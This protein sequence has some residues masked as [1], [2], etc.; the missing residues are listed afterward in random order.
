M[1]QVKKMMA[2]FIAA[3]LF[4]NP[5]MMKNSI[6]EARAEEAGAAEETGGETETAEETEVEAETG[7]IKET[8]SE[9]VQQEEAPAGEPLQA[10]ENI[11]N[12]ANEAVKVVA[13]KGVKVKGGEDVSALETPA[14]FT[15]EVEIEAPQNV[16]VGEVQLAY[17]CNDKT[18]VYEKDYNL[19]GI[20]WCPGPEGGNCEIEVNLNEYSA[21][22]AYELTYVDVNAGMGSD[23]IH[24]N[25]N[26]ETQECIE[27]KENAE[28]GRRFPYKGEANFTVAKSQ[29]ED[30]VYP[31]ILSVKRIT[32][33]DI[34]GDTEIQYEVEYRE[35]GSGVKSISLEFTDGDSFWVESFRY[36]GDVLPAGTGK[37]IISSQSRYP[38]NYYLVSASI[39]DNA[40]NQ[41]YYSKQENG[42][43]YVA[44]CP[45]GE[46]RIT[47]SDNSYEVKL[48]PYEGL[49]LK[50]LRIEG[51]DDKDNLSAG[52]AFEVV[53]TVVNDGA[54][55]KRV[56]PEACSV[57]WDRQYKGTWEYESDIFGTGEGAVLKAGEEKDVHF[58]VNI[59]PYAVKGARKLD[60]IRIGFYQNAWTMKD[61]ILYQG[62]SE[63]ALLEGMLPVE[64]VPFIERPIVDRVNYNKEIDYTVANSD[65][66]D[67]VYPEITSIKLLTTGDIYSNTS[68]QYEV[69]YSEEG[70]GVK[71]IQMS[72]QN[73]DG[74]V[75]V[76][77]YSGEALSAGKGSIVVGNADGWR[78]AGV[79]Y[80]YAFSI[81]DNAGNCTFYSKAENG[82]D[83]V[84][85]GQGEIKSLTVPDNS[86]EVKLMP[87]QGVKL[88]GVR[89][90]EGVDK[91]NLS[92]G[93]TF[94][95]IATVVND[96]AEDKSVVPRSCC[97]N[98]NSPTDQNGLQKGVEGTGN[99]FT[100]APGA[101]GEIHFKMSINAWAEKGT[102]ELSY[103]GINPGGGRVNNELNYHNMNDGILE[104]LVYSAGEDVGA[105]ADLVQYD[106][107]IDYTVANSET[108]DGEAPFIERIVVNTKDIKAPGTV[109]LA[110]YTSEEGF[111]KIESVNGLLVDKNNKKNEVYLSES[112]KLIYSEEKGCFLWNIQLG[113]SVVKGAYD[114][115]YIG[116]TDQAGNYRTYLMQEN[117]KLMDQDLGVAAPSVD[118]V[119]LVVVEAKSEN[120]D[121]D[122]PVL[123]SFALVDGNTNNDGKIQFR[124]EAED[125]SGLGD[126][127]VFYDN[128]ETGETISLLSQSAVKEGEGYIYDFTVDKY[129][130]S[131]EYELATVLLCDGSERKNSGY[132][133]YDK[134]QSVL[135]S[136]GID[137]METVPV[138]GSFDLRISP[139]EDFTI[140]DIQKEDITKV[141]DDL[142]EEGTIVVKGSYVEDSAGE[143]LP[144]AFLEKAIEKKLTVIVPDETS[145]SEIVIDGTKIEQASVKD[146]EL[147]VQ[148]DAMMEEKIE[149]G[150]TEDDIYYPVKVVISDE[151]FP[152]KLRV[153]LDKDFLDKCKSNPVR[154]SKVDPDG[155]ITVIQD[156]VKADADGY[157][158]VEFADGIGGAASS[159]VLY[160]GADGINAQ[161]DTVSGN[162]FIISSQEAG[163][164][165]L[166]D[167]NQDGRVNLFDLMEC[168]NHVAK[169]TTLTGEK[170]VRA[171][172][173][174]NGTVNLLDL[175]RILNYV[176]KKTTTV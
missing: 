93:D 36:S 8:L 115:S 100:L 87:Y 164:G 123:K 31:E 60:S 95:V 127:R 21:V 131:G 165:T 35:T 149:V 145:S 152:I 25:Y 51:V 23:Y 76:F 101:K 67:G 102:W 136:E 159:Q 13:V 68:V 130:S 138:S 47:I 105:V 156:N 17:I 40:G 24:Y 108:P 128:L 26:S 70:S 96:S 169:K 32:A 113:S 78:S 153:K 10:A 117:G 135:I 80:L 33:G 139:S 65:N 88:Q 167:I 168:L 42:S 170:F 126:M 141:V 91:D 166:G 16:P 151:K 28:S 41:L 34:Y 27:Y 150:K 125:A 146:V 147:K 174:G 3:A 142:K 77:D 75:V 134:E 83:Y 92:A 54:E 20:T 114:L 133:R 160:S 111:A 97:I 18:L 155:K 81:E 122:P 86:Y 19:E 109:E 137:G 73:A 63:K 120:Q 61:G 53:A 121:F 4:V 90:T 15:V 11:D 45:E 74:N 132:Y 112:N 172:V 43:D 144:Q 89:M 57:T 106:K 162:Q 116:I 14:Q 56:D 49:K 66:E 52:D 129:C 161:A 82:E 175:M 94:E 69:G 12:T 104:G 30:L 173:D 163:E 6:Q 55:D 176:A 71:G 140:T 44:G 38:E 103:I 58:K 110:I 59:N 85:W 48:T 84:T 124:V 107:A 39:E 118:P 9:D 29:N 72:F 158:T 64:D 5:C 79:Y 154:F 157:L 143:S 148:R 50:G 2:F 22:G 7:E 37:V 98:W 171:D 99:V 119:Q 62:N 46:K 1:R